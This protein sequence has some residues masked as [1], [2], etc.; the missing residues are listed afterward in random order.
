[1]FCFNVMCFFVWFFLAFSH[2][3]ILLQAPSLWLVL[4][5]Q[6]S[7]HSFPLPFATWSC[8]MKFF[9][10]SL[11]DCLI[12]LFCVP[13]LCVFQSEVNHAYDVRLYNIITKCYLVICFAALVIH[14]TNSNF[15]YCL[16]FRQENICKKFF[17][18]FRFSQLQILTLLQPFTEFLNYRSCLLLRLCVF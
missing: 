17:S 2:G 3:G 13:Q 14:L 5:L 4:P 7:L 9:I 11:P 18:S 12:Q 8:D 1:M 6:C 10:I 15:S 16:L